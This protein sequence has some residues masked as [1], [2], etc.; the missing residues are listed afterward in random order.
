MQMND[1]GSYFWGWLT[2]VLAALSLQDIIF[3]AGAMFTAIF[4][5]CTYLSNDK[6]NKAIAEANRRQ[7]E[8][9]AR[10][11]DNQQITPKEFIAA[12]KNLKGGTDEQA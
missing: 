7:T 10:L 6:K 8:I 5:V 2:G 3:A 9:L 11:V 12:T 1:K 4:T